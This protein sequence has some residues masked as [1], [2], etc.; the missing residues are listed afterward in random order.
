MKTKETRGIT[1]SSL[2]VT[3]I[4]LII[5]AGVSVSMISGENG[6]INQTK[7]AKDQTQ[8]ASIEEQKQLI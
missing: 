4:V 3:M 8:R 7:N 6:I 2:V 1:L 5:L